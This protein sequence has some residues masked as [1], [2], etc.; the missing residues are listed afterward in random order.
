LPIRATHD[1]DLGIDRAILGLRGDRWITDTVD[2]VMLAAACISDDDAMTEL[3]VRR[4][5]SD[6][7]AAVRWIREQFTSPQPT[8]ARRVAAHV[9]GKENGKWAVT[10]ARRF[11]EILQ[12]LQPAS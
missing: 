9:G 1:V 8:A 7:R 2:A 4:K 5:R 3:A 12:D 10:V 11:V 6:V